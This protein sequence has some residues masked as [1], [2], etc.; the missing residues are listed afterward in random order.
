MNQIKEE[1][2]ESSIRQQMPSFKAQDPLIKV[3]LRTEEDPRMTKVSDVFAKEDKVH[4]VNLIK[5]YKD[6]FT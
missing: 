1:E 5:Q 6:S 4:L 2:L 3:N